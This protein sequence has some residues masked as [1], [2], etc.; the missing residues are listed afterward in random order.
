L[1]RRRRRQIELADVDSLGNSNSRRESKPKTFGNVIAKA[2]IIS[3][4]SFHLQRE[5]GRCLE[6]S[7]G[8]NFPG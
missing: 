8:E 7:T 3:L 2:Y 1:R 6:I 5:R 4:D